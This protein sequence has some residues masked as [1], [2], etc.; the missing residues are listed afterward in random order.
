LKFEERLLL[1]KSYAASQLQNRSGAP[2]FWF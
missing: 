2:D 1:F